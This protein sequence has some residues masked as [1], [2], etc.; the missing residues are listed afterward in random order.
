MAY[1]K[2]QKAL[3]NG[4]WTNPLGVLHLLNSYVGG[5]WFWLCPLLEPLQKYIHAIRVLQVTLF[6]LMLG[7]YIPDSCNHDAA[8][9]LDRLRRRLAILVLAQAP[10]RDWCNIWLKRKWLYLGHTLRQHE[11]HITRKAFMAL[12]SVKAAV[13]SPWSHIVSWGRERL[14]MSLGCMST[15]DDLQRI[16]TNKDAWFNLHTGVV[17]G[18]QLQHPIVH[19]CE[20]RHWRDAF[21]IHTEW[22]LGASLHVMADAETGVLQVILGWLN[23]TE[24]MQSFS[25]VGDIQNVIHLWLQHLQFEFAGISVE[26]FLERWIFEAFTSELMQLH[27]FVFREYSKILTF[28][29]VSREI[30]VSMLA[31]Q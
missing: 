24:G 31:L 28:Q 27:D 20:L 10:Q 16:S 2:L 6:V 5:V 19:C 26:F 29:I 13:P 7:L 3:R 14:A 17:L 22:R 1:E 8:M 4:S 15:L 25:R 9:H 18:Y 30:S 11:A 21:R 23:V 12:V